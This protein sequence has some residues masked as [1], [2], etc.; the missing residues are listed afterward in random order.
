MIIAT[1]EATGV[2]AHLCAA[3]VE[4]FNDTTACVAV[5]LLA[6][7]LVSAIGI[8]TPVEQGQ[9]GTVTASPYQPARKLVQDQLGHAL[10]F[11]LHFN[12]DVD[13]QCLVTTQTDV[14]RGLFSS[15]LVDLLGCDG[16]F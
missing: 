11:G 15:P 7:V 13:H 14:G 12:V 8:S 3:V 2:N 1:I 10:S 9:L 16:K 4:Q 5:A 6:R